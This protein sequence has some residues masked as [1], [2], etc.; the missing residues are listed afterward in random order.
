MKTGR[1]TIGETVIDISAQQRNAVENSQ[2]IVPDSPQYTTKLPETLVST[3]ISV[4][5]ETTLA[6]T[7]RLLA[8]GRSQV[9]LLNFASARN[10]GGG[11]LGGALAQ[12]ESIAAASSLYSCQTAG[13]I[14]DHFYAYHEKH[15]TP[16]YSHRCI[17]SPM[18]PVF[19]DDEN[20]L[21]PEPY[22]AN[23]LTCAAVNQG[24]ALT[25]G[26]STTSVQTTMRERIKHILSIAATTGNRH[27][28]L[29]AFGCGVFKNDPKFVAGCF[30]HYLSH[31]FAGAFAEVVFAVPGGVTSQNYVAFAQLFS[32]PDIQFQPKLKSKAKKGADRIESPAAEIESTSHCDAADHPDTVSASTSEDTLDLSD[33]TTS[34][35]ASAS[36]TK[37]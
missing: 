24:Y 3:E 23:M 11:F 17:Y 6:A 22:F 8:S 16:L 13:H 7:R 26:L 18:V 1:Y 2:V 28:I 31:E 29:G 12:E 15:L 35:S 20:I 25:K 5:Q 32:D 37:L 34:T 19:R 27:L 4:T 33:A 36:T 21:L 10:P 30:Q 9:M 14:Y